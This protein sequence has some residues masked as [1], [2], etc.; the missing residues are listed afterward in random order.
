MTRHEMNWEFNILD[1]RDFGR[2]EALN[3]TKVM[4]DRDDLVTKSEMEEAIGTSKH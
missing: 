1:F 4:V 2:K 3:G